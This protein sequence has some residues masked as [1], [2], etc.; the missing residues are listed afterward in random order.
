MDLLVVDTPPGQPAFP[1][2][3]PAAADA[4]LVPM[5]P[6][7]DDPLGAAPIARGLARHPA[8]AFVP[9]PVPPRSRQTDGAA[10]QLAA[11]GPV[12]PARMT[13]RADFP[14]AAIGGKAA[15]EFTGKAAEEV[16]ALHACAT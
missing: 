11:A 4:V 13:F 12:A 2:A 1:P 3:L 9:S 6:T 7:P 10:R 5:R 16:A 8:R 14:A 15:G